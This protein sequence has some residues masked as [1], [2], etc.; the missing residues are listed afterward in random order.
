MSP[1]PPRFA[2][3]SGLMGIR[4]TPRGVHLNGRLSLLELAEACDVFAKWCT[5]PV[6][7]TPANAL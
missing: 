1:S 6:S 7:A 3:S 2:P 5:V 4:P